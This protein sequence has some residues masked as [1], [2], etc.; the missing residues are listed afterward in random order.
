MKR[1]IASL[2]AAF[3]DYVKNRSMVSEASRNRKLELINTYYLAESDAKNFIA[4]WEQADNLRRD[5]TAVRIV[6]TDSGGEVYTEGGGIEPTKY[7]FVLEG[8]EWRIDRIQ[9]H[10]ICH[11]KN[12]TNIPSD[13]EDCPYC[14]TK[15]HEVASIL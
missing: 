12:E 11:I 14:G 7:C 5:E 9:M 3:N 6:L 13:E 1:N 4:L 15:W 2:E 10:C 8:R